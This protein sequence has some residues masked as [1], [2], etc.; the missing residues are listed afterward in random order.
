MCVVICARSGIQCYI[1]FVR[2]VKGMSVRIFA[3]E[4][5]WL[6][7]WASMFRCKGTFCNYLGYVKVAC[8]IE[9]ADVAVFNRPAIRR[10]KEAVGKAGRLATRG[11]CWVRRA[12]I[13]EMLRM[14]GG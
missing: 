5:E 7:A 2:K 10:A 1:A 14:A 3:V 11:K 8:L 12:R 13:E 6:L 4:L 9:Q